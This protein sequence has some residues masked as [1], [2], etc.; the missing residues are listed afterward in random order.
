MFTRKQLAEC[1]ARELQKR[2]D[3]YPRWVRERRMQQ[4]FA[5]EQIALM[6]AIYRVLIN[7][8]DDEISKQT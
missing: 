4:R 7:A 2:R 6:E 8:T 3:N 1:A 5:D